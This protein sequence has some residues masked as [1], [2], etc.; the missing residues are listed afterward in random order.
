MEMEKIM[1][2]MLRFMR[3]PNSAN[4]ETDFKVALIC[5]IYNLNIEFQKNRKCLNEIKEELRKIKNK[6]YR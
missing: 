1:K 2:L 3:N 4:P 5:G 6:I